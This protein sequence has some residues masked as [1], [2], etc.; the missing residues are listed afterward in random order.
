VFGKK[1][2]GRG[3]EIR[4][5]IL[6]F[7]IFA[8]LSIGQA[9]AKGTGLIFVSNER[10]HSITVID[11]KTYKPIA[12]ID[13]GRRPRDM[14]WSQDKTKLYV[15]AS[16]DDRIEI[17]DVATSKVIGYVHPDEDPEMFD[18]TPDGKTLIASNE[19]DNMVSFVDIETD[20]ITAQI[21]TGVEPEG[22]TI[23]PDGKF[24]YV[25]AEV[26][27]MIHVIDIE[28]TKT[29]ADI[30]VGSRPRRA[31]FTS[32][33]KEYWVTNEVSGYVSVI[34][35]ETHK[36]TERVTF[37]PPGLRE[38]DITPVGINLNPD[39]KT[40]YVTLGHANRLAL[41][42]V[43]T[44]KVRKYLVV[45]VRAWNVEFSSDNKKLFVVNSGSDDVTVIDVENEEVIKTFPVGRYPHT[46]RIDD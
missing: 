4:K 29:I 18:I 21:P 34:N 8:S 9:S 7:V 24:V 13:S 19:D 25:T 2:T 32:D 30:L 44:K 20:K 33:G 39:G 26:S 5:F 36:E 46:L 12:S 11:P 41:V 42:D 23:S 31:F 37:E 17:I 15:A 16:D 35:T 28:N 14:Q 45:G 22:V 43:A 6:T 27:E 40:A 3:M 38:G 10:D 1:I